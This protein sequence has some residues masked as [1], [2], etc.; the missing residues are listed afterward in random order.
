MKN[1]SIEIGNKIHGFIVKQI[2]NA[3]LIASQNIIFEHERTGAKLLFMKNKDENKSFSI[4]FKTPALDDKG[5]P[6]IFEHITLSGSKKYPEPELFTP[7]A[8]KSFNTYMN[9]FTANTITSY[10]LASLSEK[11]L[12]SL[13]EFYMSGLFEPLIYQEPKLL[14]REGFRYELKDKDDDLKISGIVY[15]EMKGAYTHLRETY[16][17][18]LRSSFENSLVAHDSGGIP[19]EITKLEYKEI[20]EFH[21]TYYHPS[22]S[23]I[24]LYGNLDYT[25][26]LK[27]IDDEYFSKYKKKEIFIEKGKIKPYTKTKNFR[28]EFPAEKSQEPR[29]NTNITYTFVLNEITKENTMN[30]MIL[31]ELLNSKNLPFM[32]NMEKKLNG[33]TAYSYVDLDKPT[34]I[35]VF[36]LYSADE[37]DENIFKKIVDESIET[38]I[39]N[40]IEKD[41]F[42]ATINEIKLQTLLQLEDKDLGVNSSTSNAIFWSTFDSL[43]YYKIFEE[44]LEKINEKTLKNLCKKYL[45]KNKHRAIASTVLIAGKAEKNLKKEKETLKNLKNNLNYYK[46]NKLIA[47]TKDFENWC[48]KP[49]SEEIIN[50]FLNVKIKDLENIESKLIINEEI[51]N[52]TKIISTPLNIGKLSSVKIILDIS[53]LPIKHLQAS[54]LYLDLLGELDTENLNKEE[55]SIKNKMYNSNSSIYL[56][57]EYDIN[58]KAMYQLVI[59]WIGEHKYIKNAF[60]II[61]ETLLKTKTSDISAIKNELQKLIAK[62]KISFKTDSLNYQKIRCQ[63]NFDE[64]SAYKNHIN[65]VSM[66][67]FIT[68]M[69]NL[70]ED[71]PYSITDIFN[72]TL[73]NLLN[74]NNAI[75]QIISDEKNIKKAQNECLSF[76]KTLDDTKN[77]KVNYKQLLLHNKSEAYINGSDVHHNI[78][79]AKT[80]NYSGKNIVIS[81]LINDMF[82]LPEL[83]LAKGAYGAYSSLQRFTSTIYTYRDPNIEESFNII[84]KLP[85]FLENL[86]LTQ[87]EIDN[88][89]IGAYSSLIPRGG[90]ITLART[91]QNFYIKNILNADIVKMQT[92]AKATTL[93]DVKDFSKVIQEILDNS[94][95]SSSGQLEKLKKSNLFESFVSI[96]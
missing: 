7:L 25:K 40:G 18:T 91:Y 49:A 37:K 27:F 67:D 72:K 2:E 83:R 47:K 1:N 5:K 26:F 77:E 10:P 17:N 95:K 93:Q 41:I 36:A 62:L 78:I 87:K 57:Q 73:K 52:N 39:D 9:A 28:Y 88:Y 48:S 33:Y 3:P 55:L 42:D 76:L 54:S 13:A 69:L 19:D 24:Q 85:E 94:N 44:V 60:E 31:S 71:E 96:D 92:E 66:N 75:I 81:N 15:S 38:I 65:G 50:K 64:I 12:L 21:K 35:L 11:Q 34:P 59:S 84:N 16:L 74:S 90:A 45:N 6:H 43:N 46:T 4:S 20:L 32:Q 56:N 79:S 89:I 80:P 68:Y 61:K 8:N 29:K 58:G 51:I 23:F 70:C 86:N 63:A 82:L 14:D 30:L 53:T 22:N